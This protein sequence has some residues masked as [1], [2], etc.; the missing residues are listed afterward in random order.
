[1]PVTSELLKYQ[2]DWLRKWKML[3]SS[4]RATVLLSSMQGGRVLLLVARCAWAELHLS[5]TH[6]SLGFSLLLESTPARHA[7]MSALGQ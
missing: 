5:Q 2:C 7:R 6:N 3:G 4:Y 1:M